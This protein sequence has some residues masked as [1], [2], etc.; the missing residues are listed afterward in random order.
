[1]P[2]GGLHIRPLQ[3]FCEISA[4]LFWQD[5]QVV[6]D[7][8]P[9]NENKRCAMNETGHRFSPRPH[10]FPSGCDRQTIAVRDA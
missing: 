4:P 3:D 5:V 6:V 8:F 9:E 1:M 10:R 2:Q 7:F